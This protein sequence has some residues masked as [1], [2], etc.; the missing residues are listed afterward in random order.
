MPRSRSGPWLLAIF[1]PVMAIK[2]CSVGGLLLLWQLASSSGW[3]PPMFFPAPREVWQEAS[4]LFEDG[5]IWQAVLVSSRRVFSG[6]GLAALISIP[7]GVVMA[8]WWPAKA[9]FDP[10][11]SLLRPLP[12][13]TW[14][15]LTILWLGIGEGQKTAIVF[16]GTWIYVLL[17]TY[18]STRRVDPML[19]RAA[20]NLG[21]NSFQVMRVVLMAALPGII[22]G[23]KV[24]LAIAWSCVITAEMVAARIGLGA[25][26]WRAKDG[27]NL[28]LVLVGMIGISITVLIADFIV[29]RLEYIFL[30]WERARR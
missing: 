17:Y 19:I 20:R 28:G 25:T 11:V 27:A 26:I 3:L 23:L 4:F 16:A 8:V 29:D 13:I 14:I 2:I 12:S 18:E 9:A 15:P 24:T 30:P 10:L 1:S 7:L 5:E 22:S 21:A 6:F